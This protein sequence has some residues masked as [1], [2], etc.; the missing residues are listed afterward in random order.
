MQAGTVVQQIGLGDV[1]AHA[2]T[3]QHDRD[4]RVLLADVLVEAGQVAHDLAPAIVIGEMPE[5]P[6]FGSF[7]MSTQVR[8]AH[9]IA[10]F[11]EFFR[12]GAIATAV[13][14]HAVGQ[15]NHCLEAALG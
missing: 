11:T 4:A 10:L 9:A 12:Q 13:F 7:A 15:Q 1:T 5:C 14:G 8:R 3:E 6:V 2:V